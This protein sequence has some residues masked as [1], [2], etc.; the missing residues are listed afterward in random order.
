M[1]DVTTENGQ[2]IPETIAA[3][4]TKITDLRAVIRRGIS[5]QRYLAYLHDHYDEESLDEDDKCCVLCKCE[6]AKVR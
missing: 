6:F 5:K 1:E 4:S 3:L 2:T